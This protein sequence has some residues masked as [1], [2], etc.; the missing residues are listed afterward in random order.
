MTTFGDRQC[1]ELFH[2]LFLAQLGQKVDKKR[3]ALKGGCNLRFFFGSPRYSEDMDLDVQLEP[4]ETLREKVSSILSSKPFKQLLQVRGIAIEHF[5]ESKQTET[6]QRWKLGIAIES[7]ELPLPTKIEFSRRGMGVSARFESVSAELIG[8]YGLPPIMT[9]HYPA[10]A[11]FR[12]KIQALISRSVT[13]ARDV[14]DLHLLLASGLDSKSVIRESG[15][16]VK[17]VQ[18][19]LLS[20]DFEQFK[21]QVLAYLPPEWQSQYDSSEVWD[22]MV[23]AVVES[24]QGGAL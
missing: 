23:L 20:V 12:Q 8:R 6:T 1:V 2:L 14:F 24:L 7:T 15:V 21:G 13:Q 19:R 22:R 11:A 18:N 3:Y 17:E 9:N 5:T 16:D 10:E 4:V